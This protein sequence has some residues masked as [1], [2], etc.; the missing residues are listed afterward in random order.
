MSVVAADG[1]VGFGVDDSAA[2]LREGW[3][4]SALQAV[5]RQMRTAPIK[6]DPCLVV[7]V[8]FDGITQCAF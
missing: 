3:P 6:V 4:G 2:W 7:N 1:L 5:N 8:G